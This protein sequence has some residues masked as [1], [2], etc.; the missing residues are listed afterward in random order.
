MT[1][2]PLLAEVCATTGPGDFEDSGS[3]HGAGVVMPRVHKFGGTSVDGAERLQAL[4]AIIRDQEDCS[5]VVVSAMAGVSNKLSRLADAVTRDADEVD[6]STI[7]AALKQR[8]LDVLQAIVK[9]EAPRATVAARIDEIFDGAIRLIDEGPGEE[10]ERFGD[11]LMA[12]GEDLSVELT[13]AVL[14][15]EGTPATVLDARE[16]VW[17]DSEFGAAVPDFESIRKFAPDNI[18]PLVEDGRV[19]VV[20]GFIGSEAGG[21]TTTLGRGGSDFTATLLGAALGSP[22]VVI[23]TDVDGIL[24]GDPGLVGDSRVLPDIGSEEAVE[25]SYF[26]ARVIHPAAAKHAIASEVPLRIKNSFA[27][28]RPGTLIH[29]DRSAPAAFAAVAHKTDVA[30]IRVRAFPTA[31]AYGFLARVFGVLGRHGVPV[32]LVST[33]HSST[34]FTV[35][36]DEDLSAVRGALSV[37]SDVDVLRD[38]ATVTVVGRGLLRE[39]GM[40]ALVFWAVEKTP[41]YLISQASDVSINFVVDEAEAPELVRRLHLSLIELKEGARQDAT[42]QEEASKVNEEVSGREEEDRR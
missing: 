27:P 32:D 22:E 30:L 34:A 20:Q 36:R 35:D 17:T 39:P 15:A 21:A 11:Q 25:L 3:P 28:E 10:T 4:A 1:D 12:V 38:V 29:S 14:Q 16:I 2:R 23:W 6:A 33:S 41:V 40:D 31:L 8:H 24:S 19:P 26:G 9:E 42:R 7:L 37:F 13:A 5:V 18:L